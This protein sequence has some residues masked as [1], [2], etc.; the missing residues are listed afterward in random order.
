MNNFLSAP[1]FGQPGCDDKSDSIYF[2]GVA[3][4]YNW[5]FWSGLQSREVHRCIALLYCIPLGIFTCVLEA[6]VYPAQPL[7]GP[8]P[9]PGLCYINFGTLVHVLNR[10]QIA[11]D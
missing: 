2:I 6:F 10:L 4:L 1:F 3:F 8:K 11:L 9:P 7:T 5:Y